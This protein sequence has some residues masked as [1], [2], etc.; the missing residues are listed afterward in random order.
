MLAIAFGAMAFTNAH[1]DH[2]Q[3][4]SKKSNVHWLGEKVTGSH[5]GDIAILSGLIS[6]DHGKL[7][8]ANF[9]MDMNSISNTDI[10]SEEYSQKLVAHLKNEDFFDVSN[11]PTAE[12][13]MIMATPTTEG[14]EVLG[15]LTIKGKTK[16]VSFKAK[17]QQRG[18]TL[19]A[20]GKMSFDRTKYDITY[21]SGSFFDN[22]GDRAIYDEVTLEFNIM[23][24]NK[25][26]GTH[27]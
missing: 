26:N 11:H 19:I 14:F 8:A 4:D 13:K 6:M 1:Q 20:S 16:P 2:Y 10:E 17:I 27:H 5:E 25:S 9:T 7:V 3:V 23:A 21:G 12:F 18:N 15:N 22:L 24:E